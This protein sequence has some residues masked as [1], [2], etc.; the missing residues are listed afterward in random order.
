MLASRLASPPYLAVSEC[1][2][3]DNDDTDSCAEFDEA[4]AVPRVTPASRKV[5]V[6]VAVPPKAG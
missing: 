4:A 2:P 6:P 1:V 3:T 5:I